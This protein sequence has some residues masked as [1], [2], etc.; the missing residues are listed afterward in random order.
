[1]TNA[2]RLARN[3]LAGPARAR[4]HVSATVLRIDP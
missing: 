3:E 2:A 1:M 4:D